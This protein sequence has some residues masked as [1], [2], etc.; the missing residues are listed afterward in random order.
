[1]A[2]KTVTLYGADGSA[3]PVK[4]NDNGD[5]TYS[6]TGSTLATYTSVASGELQGSASALQL[7]T[8]SC[9]LVKFKAQY[10]NAGR[11]Y[12]GGAGV[13]KKD[14]TTDATTGLELAAGEETG[15]L[16]VANLNVFFRICDNAG[17][18][19]TYLALS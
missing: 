7:P 13:T 5:S 19:L 16:P 12:L 6:P 17:D 18:D 15:W 8:I 2:D 1:M 11:V 14:G 9:K 10:D 3:V 4:Y